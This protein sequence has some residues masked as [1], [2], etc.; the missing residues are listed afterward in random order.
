M[1]PLAEEDARVV[2]VSIGVAN[3]ELAESVPAVT[4]VAVVG[5]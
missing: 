5:A 2:A 3:V 4:L 1:G